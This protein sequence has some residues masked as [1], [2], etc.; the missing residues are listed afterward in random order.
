MFLTAGENLHKVTGSS[1]SER[2]C[3][4]SIGSR[5]LLCSKQQG[6]LNL[7][8]FIFKFTNDLIYQIVSFS[9]SF[10]GS[11]FSKKNWNLLWFGYISNKE[12]CVT[13]TLVILFQPITSSF[14]S[15]NVISRG[16]LWWRRKTGSSATTTVTKTSLASSFIAPIPSRSIRQMLE[17]FSGVEFWDSIKVQGKKEK[18]R[19]SFFHVLYKTSNWALSRFSRAAM[20]KKCN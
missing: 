8:L 9:F 7:L 15:S 14:R 18:R 6:F 20:V 19:S 3:W 17:N 2:R 4:P 11:I 10:N 1:A 5:I 13:N 16:S 12:N